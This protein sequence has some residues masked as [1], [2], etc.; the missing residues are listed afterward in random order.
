MTT[1]SKT[2][3]MTVFVTNPTTGN[4]QAC[5]LLD[6][7]GIGLYEN[8]SVTLLLVEDDEHN[9]FQ[10]LRYACFREDFV[11][12]VSEPHLP[13]PAEYPSLLTVCEWTSEF[14]I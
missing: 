14:D 7:Q 8:K 3:E 6:A 10:V 4:Q 11:R 12:E 9:Y 2:T 5:T 1:E 13:E